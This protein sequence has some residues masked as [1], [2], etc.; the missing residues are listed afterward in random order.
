MKTNFYKKK[1]RK[2]TFLSLFKYLLSKKIIKIIINRQIDNASK[3]MTLDNVLITKISNV[4]IIITRYVTLR[5]NILTIESNEFLNI[6]IEDDS[7]I[8]IDCYHRKI[9]IPN[10]IIINEEYLKIILNFKYLQLSSYL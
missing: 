2:E 3:Y 10:S 8:V 6:K 1:K 4:L 5:Y 7:K 9:N